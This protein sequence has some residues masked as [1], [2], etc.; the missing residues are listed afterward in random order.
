[1]KITSYKNIELVS[2]YGK[3]QSFPGKT[4]QTPETLARV[5]QGKEFIYLMPYGTDYE[6]EGGHHIEILN[7]E[8]FNNLYSLEYLP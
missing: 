1:M 5:K 6:C 4:Y 3:M 7:Q 2:A 8:E